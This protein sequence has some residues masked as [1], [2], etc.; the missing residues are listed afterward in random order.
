MKNHMYL[1]AGDGVYLYE[2]NGNGTLSFVDHTPCGKTMYLAAEGRRMF[3]LLHETADPQ[4]TGC[5]AV[6]P[7]RIDD[8]GRLTEPCP[9][10]S[11]GGA[12]GCHLSLLDNVI[13][14]ANYVSGSIARMPLDGSPASVVSHQENGLPCGPEAKR[15]ETAHPH[16]IAPTPD[17]TYLASVDLGLDAILTYDRQLHPVCVSHLPAG[18]GP[19]HLAFSRDGKF[20]YCANELSSTVS[21]LRYERETGAF[22]HLAQLPSYMPSSD[23]EADAKQSVRNYPAAIR[24]DGEYVMVSNRGRDTVA[25]FRVSDGGASLACIAEIPTY[26]AWPRDF[27]VSGDDLIC[28]NEYGGSVTVLRMNADRTDAKL[29]DTITDIPAPIAVLCMD[30]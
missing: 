17:G 2:Q 28:T 5:S 16:F 6:I 19:R 9:A 13:Y 26:G 27:I 7:Y 23:K 29:I 3:A 21:V 24:A 22:V 18:C 10:L 30:V 8:K 20:A 14:A 11:S 12:C 1:A 4:G 25:V 15:Q